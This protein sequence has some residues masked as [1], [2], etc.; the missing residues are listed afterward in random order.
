MARGDLFINTSTD[1]P[2]RPP[3]DTQWYVE[4]IVSPAPMTLNG[5]PVPID[6]IKIIDNDHY[7]T[8]LDRDDIVRYY[9][10]YIGY[11]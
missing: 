8:V 10:H 11:K 1:E 3:G 2:F 6:R 7:F 4:K 5:I 9:Q